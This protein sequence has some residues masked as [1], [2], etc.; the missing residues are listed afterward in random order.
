MVF[1]KTR[2]WKIYCYK[3][4]WVDLGNSLSKSVSSEYFVFIKCSECVLLAFFLNSECCL[5]A[6][7]PQN[8]P[9]RP[10]SDVVFSEF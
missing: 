2:V 1:Y 5:D 6:A 10:Q 8:I 9:L 4:F 3:L 7:L